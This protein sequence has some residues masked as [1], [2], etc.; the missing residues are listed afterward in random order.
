[1]SLYRQKSFFNRWKS[2]SGST[3]ASSSSSQSQYKP[4]QTGSGNRPRSRGVSSHI[5]NK[6][7]KATSRVHS[8]AGGGTQCSNPAYSPNTSHV[9][10]NP[11]LKK[12]GSQRRLSLT[13]KDSAVQTDID[14]MESYVST[15]RR[16]T[17]SKVSSTSRDSA[18]CNGTV[19]ILE[20]SD[21]H[22]DGVDGRVVTVINKTK[23]H[24]V[25]SYP[26][27]VQQT[28]GYDPTEEMDCLLKATESTIEST[29]RS[30]S[31]AYNTMS[32][33]PLLPGGERS[34]LLGS[35]GYVCGDTTS[36][37]SASD[38]DLGDPDD[39]E[40]LLL[41]AG[42]YQGS[43]S[44][45][46]SNNTNTRWNPTSKRSSSD[47]TAHVHMMPERAYFSY[48]NASTERDATPRITPI[49]KYSH[50]R[51]GPESADLGHN[52]PDTRLT[53]LPLY[54]YEDR[55]PLHETK[56]VL[57][58]TAIPSIYVKHPTPQTSESEYLS[59]VTGSNSSFRT[60]FSGLASSVNDSG[61]PMT[62]SADSRQTS[63][64]ESS[65]SEDQICSGLSSPADELPKQTIQK[66][67]SVT[68]FQEYLRTRGVDLDLATVQSSD[69]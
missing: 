54:K 15:L 28:A 68:K 38:C 6:K 67:D 46:S 11:S 25:L 32:Q 39:L 64:T 29:S 43:F 60:D 62:A 48:H 52:R 14:L 56:Q 45:V 57:S 19:V 9:R 22:H 4:E 42:E 66:E 47:S 55:C 7:P 36:E 26:S 49:R 69:V 31:Q 5:S 34:P 10:R 41:E 23:H 58:S 3:R 8:K 61:H 1:M 35:S 18:I 20:P 59:E 63:S 2:K 13:Y 27:C 16:R 33:S 12:I 53:P 37:D 30:S 40:E 51:M 65:V 50:G 17:S 21:L 24:D 44:S